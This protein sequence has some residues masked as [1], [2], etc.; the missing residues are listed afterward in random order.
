MCYL[1]QAL[2]NVCHIDPGRPVLV[3]LVEEHVAEEFEH[4]AVARLRPRRVQVQSTDD[5][6]LYH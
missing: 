2:H 3:H 4:V 5:R 1:I 6:L